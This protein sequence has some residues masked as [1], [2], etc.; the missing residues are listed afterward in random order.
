MPRAMGYKSLLEGNTVSRRE[1]HVHESL[2]F[3]GNILGNMY[4][5]RM[6]HLPYN[7]HTLNLAEQ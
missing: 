7:S 2:Q 6:Q 3:E 5:V 4:M 1:N